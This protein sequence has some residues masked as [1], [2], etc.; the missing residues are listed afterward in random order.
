MKLL[1][2]TNIQRGCVYDGPGVRTT[3]FLKGCLFRCPWC[4]NPETQKF[5]EEWYIDDNK[6]FLNRG[7]S[8]KL[9]NECERL[10]GKICVHNCPFGIA[11]KSSSD[12]TVEDLYTILVK[13]KTLY[14][15]TDGGVTFSGGEPLCV[16]D[17]LIPLL[18]LLSIDGIRMAIETT[19]Y[20][21]AKTVELVMPFINYWI[22]D[23]K[24]HS[25]LKLN[26]SKYLEQIRTNIRLLCSKNIVFRLVFIDEMILEKGAILNKLQY[27][28]VTKI[29][30]LLCHNLGQKKYLKLRMNNVDYTA[31]TDKANQFVDY[32][33]ANK[34]D[35]FLLSV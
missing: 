1:R 17:K 23:L 16:T 9:C 28:G 6:C 15:E 14:K 21:T 29:E 7:I 33:N 13:D 3:V 26:E 4:C 24:L 2:V 5:E 31:N 18:R 12:Y 10:G 19:L 27:L 30:L 35:A 32:L 25:M 22:I 11:E 8:S 34:V 20:S